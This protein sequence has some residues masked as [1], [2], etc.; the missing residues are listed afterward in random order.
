MKISG[1]LRLLEG[2]R[3]T[4]GHRYTFFTGAGLLPATGTLR[5]NQVRTIGQLYVRHVMRAS[6]VA[7]P[8]GMPIMAV[9]CGMYAT[10]ALEPNE[11]YL[12]AAE[13]MALSPDDCGKII[14]AG[15]AIVCFDADGGTRTRYSKALRVDLLAA[16]GLEEHPEFVEVF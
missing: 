16:C 11:S 2:F 6:N 7:L 4:Q 13:G 1:F 5:A 10:K 15:D 3:A 8:H 9:W 14:R 12:D